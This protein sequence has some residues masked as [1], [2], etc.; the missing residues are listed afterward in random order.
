MGYLF[1]RMS[2][3]ISWFLFYGCQEINCIEKNFNE[4]KGDKYTS[5]FL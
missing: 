5:T 4:T 1:P 2:N 3:L